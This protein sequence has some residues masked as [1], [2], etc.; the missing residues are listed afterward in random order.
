MNDPM[1]SAAAVALA[2]VS[3]SSSTADGISNHHHHPGML[4]SEMSAFPDQRKSDRNNTDKDK[5][6][7]SRHSNGARGGNDNVNGRN[8][9]STST[10]TG[11]ASASNIE[12]E[13]DGD[14]KRY[15]CSI[16]HHSFTRKHNLK[17][18]L[19]IHTNEKPFSCSHCSSQFR[20]QYDLK[21]HEKTHTREKPFVCSTC[22]KQFA[23]ADALL[24]HSNSN[25]GCQNSDDNTHSSSV[26][27]AASGGNDH[28]LGHGHTRAADI[29]ADSIDAKRS[30]R[31]KTNPKNQHPEE[32][33]SG[34]NP[35]FGRDD[36]NDESNFFAQ[37]AIQQHKQQQQNQHQ[38]Q[39]GSQNHDTIER[40]KETLN[41]VDEISRNINMQFMKEHHSQPKN[42]LA[43][44]QA[45]PS[46][47]TLM[48]T[49]NNI[50]NSLLHNS[51]ENNV[52]DEDEEQNEDNDDDEEVDNDEESVR[53]ILGESLSNNGGLSNSNNN[54]NNRNLHA[55]NSSNIHDDNAESNEI[56]MLN[57]SLISGL[58]SDILSN[59]SSSSQGT[60]SI[61][62]SEHQFS[63]LKSL[64]ETL[65]NL[66]LRVRRVENK[67]AEMNRNQ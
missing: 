6:K 43:N 32:L 29:K 24:R 67:F 42:H 39:Q 47:E 21:R 12:T 3:S 54:N 18:H 44:L 46:Q 33:S 41:S 10:H 38:Q 30:K 55:R 66:D 8:N 52:G 1:K 40:V 4:S 22:G 57:Y 27:N 37:Q 19:L 59:S 65:Q 50:G 49:A 25:T 53:K 15:I 11:S 58:L 35:V 31:Q 45:L 13:L 60:Q 20:R 64:L 23:R 34:I 17:S 36:L 14:E 28:G 56:P 48:V 63:V 16:C 51:G 7:D 9:G 61:Q 26:S 5:G 62:L 2:A